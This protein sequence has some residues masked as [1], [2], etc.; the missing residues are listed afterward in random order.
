MEHMDLAEG[1]WGREVYKKTRV[2]DKTKELG[3]T[4]TMFKG[5]F[6]SNN[7]SGYYIRRLVLHCPCFADE[8]TGAQT[9]SI[10]C[11]APCPTAVRTEVLESV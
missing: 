8:E 2:Q 3:G 5:S 11:S 6:I 1:Q 10:K 9:H 7:E 4:Q